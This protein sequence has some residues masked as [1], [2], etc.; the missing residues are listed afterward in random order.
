[1]RAITVILLFVVTLGC[2][3]ERENELP[4]ADWGFVPS[5]PDGAE[6]QAIRPLSPTT[7]LDAKAVALGNEL[8]H[9]SV[10]SGADVSCASCHDLTDGG[11]DGVPRSIGVSGKAVARNSPT[12]FNA[13]LHFRQ[14]WD[15]RAATLEEQI[16]GP[17]NHRDEMASNWP[18]AI[19]RVTNKGDYSDRFQELYGEPPSEATIK[20]AISTFERSLITLDAPFDRFLAGET[21]ALSDEAKIGWERFR[22]FGCISCHQGVAIGGNMFQVF[23][24]FG[25]PYEEK[26]GERADLGRYEVTNR[27]EDK[28]WFKVPSLRN[29]AATAPYFHDGSVEE[30]ADAIRLMLRYQLGRAPKDEDVKSLEQ[31]LRSLSGNWNGKPVE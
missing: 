19:A 23:G 25:N 31:F 21:D 2:S 24:V 18:D 7:G 9:D 14:F 11:M 1:M 27:D 29:V 30:L 6:A 13:A 4:T 26:G 8:F 3:D 10:L 28:Y 15:G 16:D 12:V 17:I 5:S 20:S 22:A